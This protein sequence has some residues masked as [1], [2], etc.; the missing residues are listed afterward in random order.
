MYKNFDYDAITRA[1][2]PTK[3]TAMEAVNLSRIWDNSYYNPKNKDSTD[4]QRKSDVLFADM[5]VNTQGVYKAKKIQKGSE[6]HKKAYTHFKNLLNKH[7]KELGLKHHPL[8]IMDHNTL[9]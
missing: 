6:Q 4:W 3:K 7:R 9:N 5:M 1:F 8:E 2:Y